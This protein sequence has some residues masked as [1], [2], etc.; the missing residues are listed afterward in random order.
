M[1]NLALSG[2]GKI[3]WVASDSFDLNPGKTPKNSPPARSGT[4]NIDQLATLAETGMLG[5]K[6]SA[7]RKAPVDLKEVTQMRSFAI[8]NSSTGHPLKSQLRF[9]RYATVRGLRDFET[10]LERHWNDY[11]FFYLQIKADSLSIAD[12]SDPSDREWL[13][14]VDA[15]LAGLISGFLPEVFAL[16]GDVSRTFSGGESVPAIVHSDRIA[17]Q[18]PVGLG[19]PDFENGQ[20]SDWGTLNQ[21]LLLL[22]AHANRLDEVINIEPVRA[23]VPA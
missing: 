22:M 11:D 17:I 5:T 21:W 12:T 3:I 8:T 9:E 1:Q 2:G 6:A 10:I 7:W 16:S 18:E 13:E 19:Q 20:L 23:A 14:M 15:W 4:P